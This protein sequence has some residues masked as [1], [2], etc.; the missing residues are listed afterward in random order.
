[1][2]FWEEREPESADSDPP[3][4]RVHVFHQSDLTQL[5]LCPERARQL[6]TGLVADT[7]NDTTATGTA[8][9]EGIEVR[10]N[11]GS[12]AEAIEVA[13]TRFAE[14]ARD[15]RFEWK[16]V[17]SGGYDT[18]SKHIGQALRNWD[19]LVFPLLGPSQGI[20]VNFELLLD[21]RRDGDGAITEIRLAGCM[22]YVDDV[23]VW[24]W[25]A[26]GNLRKYQ[27]DYGGQG[28]ELKRWGLQP[29][30]YTFAAEAMGLLDGPTLHFNFAALSKTSPQ[31]VILPCERNAQHWQWLAALCWNAV[32]MLRSDLARWP[33]T[34]NHG[35][36]SEL[37]CPAYHTCPRSLAP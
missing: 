31:A 24:D 11:G 9:H 33:M 14:L 30:V 20:E 36:C 15:P 3:N 29:T 16:K 10:L 17:R 18:V 37:W 25:K 35:L 23:A 13:H 26:P 5:Q 28:W 22:D 27:A 1:M 21:E 19:T 8:V 2:R 4:R 6:W 12:V 34:D 7:E 32:E